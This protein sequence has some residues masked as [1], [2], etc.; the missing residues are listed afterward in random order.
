MS[1]S[2]NKVKQSEAI[3]EQHQLIVDTFSTEPGQKLLAQ[4]AKE[5]IW[6]SQLTKDPHQ[7]Y[8]RIGV[9]ELVTHF[10]NVLEE[11]K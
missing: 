7:L 10:C 6:S 11:A 1:D 3:K 5:Y 2:D 4:L 8:A 9:Q